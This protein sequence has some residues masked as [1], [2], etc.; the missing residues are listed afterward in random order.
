MWL[1]PSIGRP[2]NSTGR[3]ASC[4]ASTSN[5]EPSSSLTNSTP[6]PA[7]RIHRGWVFTVAGAHLRIVLPS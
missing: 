7:D 4:T 3:A 5:S 6:F 1:T 2:S